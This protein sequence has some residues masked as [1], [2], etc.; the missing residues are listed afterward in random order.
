MGKKIFTLLLSI[1]LSSALYGCS[2]SNDSANDT[3]TI[4]NKEDT[5]EEFKSFFK[6]YDTL[7]LN[8]YNSIN[9]L[10]SLNKTEAQDTLD[11]SI[12]VLQNAYSKINEYQRGYDKKSD[13][14]NALDNLQSALF[15]L[16]DAKKCAIKYLDS[17]S[18]DD[19]DSY[20]DILDIS[21]D[22]YNKNSEYKEK[23]GIEDLEIKTENSSDNTNSSDSSAKKTSDKNLNKSKTTNTTKK[24]YC[25]TCGRE[26]TKEM[27]EA[28]NRCEKCQQNRENSS[29]STTDTLENDRNGDGVL[30]HYDDYDD[31]EG[32]DSTEY[33]DESETNNN[34]NDNINYHTEKQDD[35]GT[36]IPNN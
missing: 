12:K 35:G 22:Y 30:D 4:A 14:Y 21:M 16:A 33:S 36:L 7:Y 8:H 2:I 20:K 11:R 17:N 5:L 31:Y 27:K 32:D 1:I 3:T 23:L 6:T 28:T 24:Y 19:Y 34:S 13:E 25:G 9:N 29:T 10:E 15:N 18:Y 26:I